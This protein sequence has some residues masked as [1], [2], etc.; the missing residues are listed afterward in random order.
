MSFAQAAPILCAGVTTYKALKETEARAVE[1]GGP[2]RFARFGGGR[3]LLR[4]QKKRKEEE[5]F[6]LLGPQ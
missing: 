3:R 4:K 5:V 2:T 1:H 6:A